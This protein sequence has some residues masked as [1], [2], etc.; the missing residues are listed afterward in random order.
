MFR[1]YA[2]T[3]KATSTMAKRRYVGAIR[4]ITPFLVLASM[5]LGGTYYVLFAAMNQFIDNDASIGA[6]HV[7]QYL[8]GRPGEIAR[9]ESKAEFSSSA[10]DFL[11]AEAK[12]QNLV[13]VKL[14]GTDGQVMSALTWPGTASK[15]GA[16]STFHSVQPTAKGEKHFE[17]VSD[18]SVRRGELQRELVWAVVAL[19]FLTAC[20]FGVPAFVF[21]R[22]VGRRERGEERMEFMA[23]HDTLTDLL[24]R[25][26][27]NK[28]FDAKLADDALEQ[29]ALH[30]VDVDRFKS[31]NDSLG[32]NVGDEVIKAV[33]VRLQSL[34]GP[35]DFVSRFGGDEFVM[36]QS[37]IR[38]ETDAEARAVA[39]R[40]AI[41]E[42]LQTGEHQI[43]VTASVGTALFP[44][45]GKKTVELE[46]AADLALYSAK[47]DGRDT[48]RM[49]DPKMDAA[50]EARRRIEKAL[51]HAFSTETFDLHFQPIVVADCKKLLGF[52]VL[53]RLQTQDGEDVP[54]SDFIPVAE[55]MGL[56]S[57]IGA[58]VIRKACVT[59]A[60][61][62]D[63]LTIA[64]NMSPRQFENGELCDI[65]E[66][67]LADSGLAASRLELEITE[68]LLVSDTERVMTQLRRLKSIGVSI[69]M[70]DFGTGYSSL[71]YLW[72]FPFDKLK[73]D[74]SF[75]RVMA[76]GDEQV[77][78]IL[79]TIISLG[80]TLNLQVTAEGVETAEQADMLKKLNCNQLQ[81]YYFGRPAPEC[82]V[83]ATILTKAKAEIDD[84]MRQ[85]ASP[86][87]LA[88]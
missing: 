75:M 26:A 20:S 42:P 14:V 83:A 6:S 44:R 58:W 63:D 85:L 78:S 52:E 33:A 43:R 16:I 41:Q 51:L 1:R 11:R 5:F 32:H 38:G 86:T 3:R 23:H 65:V 72:Q 88:S 4:T 8:E 53:L 73:I 17:I 56:I 28:A 45:D 79:N 60:T 55:D 24:N 7:A 40:H 84:R 77:S 69:A 21:L 67:A 87:A 18:Q 37:D 34:M 59:A 66:A 47:A 48:C 35:R 70:D 22:E 64:V 13:S 50:L 2:G 25:P 46:K 57:Q 36:A 9:F 31:V 80:R 10:M 76:E 27:F 68:G 82:D 12:A 71:S 54:P 61:W 62:P 30:F 81:G 15:D 74:R 49:Y 19:G 39:I 29:C